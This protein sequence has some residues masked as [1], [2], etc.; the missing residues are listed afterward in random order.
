M[1]R[2]WINRLVFVLMLLLGADLIWA[3]AEYLDKDNEQPFMDI[4]IHTSIWTL[5]VGGGVV[6]MIGGFVALIHSFVADD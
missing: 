5:L 2:K 3:S 4:I 1:P 6:L